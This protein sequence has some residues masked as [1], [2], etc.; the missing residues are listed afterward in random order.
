[1]SERETPLASPARLI[2]NFNI[3]VNC[4]A[5]SD[6]KRVALNKQVE[7]GEAYHEVLVSLV[8]AHPFISLLTSL[9]WDFHFQCTQVLFLL[10]H[11]L[12][13]K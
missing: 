8:A 1:V 7:R 12:L 6:I 3:A 2:N 5:L 4:E 13:I 9:L 10:M 11:M